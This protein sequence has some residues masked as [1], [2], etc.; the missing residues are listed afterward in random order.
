M[1]TTYISPRARVLGIES[2]CLIANSPMGAIEN[3][4]Q[5]HSEIPQGDTQDNCFS[6]GRI[7]GDIW[8]E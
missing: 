5:I 8:D 4:S 3:G 1:K 2:E 7:S 6:N